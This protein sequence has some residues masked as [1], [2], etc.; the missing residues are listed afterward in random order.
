M[1]SHVNLNTISNANPLYVPQNLGFSFSKKHN[2]NNNSQ[3]TA[4]ELYVPSIY[5]VMDKLHS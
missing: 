5:L 3:V 2:W 1:L 4:I